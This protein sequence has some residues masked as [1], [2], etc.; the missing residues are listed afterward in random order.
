MEIAAIIEENERRKIALTSPYDPVKGIGCCGRRV[1]CRDEWLPQAVVDEC[2][3]YSALPE[4][5][6]RRVRVRHDFEYWCA[7]CATVR[8]KLTGQPV[9]LTLNAPQRRVLA[10]MESQRTA[11]QPVRVILLKARQW[12]GSTLVQMYMAWM[13]LVRHTGW[14]SLICGHLRQSARSIKGMYRLLLRHYPRELLDDDAPKIE[15]KNF[16]G[17]SD[18]Q[19]ITGRDSL[20]IMGTAVSEDAVR[21]YNLAM[22]HLT[23]VAFWPET[24]MH[25]PQD[26]MRSVNGTVTRTA[27]TVVALESTANGVGQFFHTEWLRANTGESDKQPVFVPW[28]EIE[29]YRSPVRDVLHLWESMDDYERG[30]WRDGRTL[31]MIQW[32]HDKRK[33]AAS[34]A[35]MMAEFP[36][37]D[38]E[39]FVCTDH[40]VFDLEHLDRMRQHCQ[41]PQFTGDV[42]ADYKT[43]NHVHFVQAASGLMKVW[44]LPEPG[45]KYVVAV[46]IGGRSDE[47]DYSVI[48]VLDVRDPANS[49]PEVVAQWRGHLD[50]DLLAWKAAQ[51]ATLYNRAPLVVESNTLETGRGTEGA[52]GKFLLHE[53]ART[54]P[55][56]YRRNATHFGFHTNVS[57][58]KAMLSNLIAA[59]RDGTY[60]ERDHEALDEMAT[61]EHTSNGAYEA[62]KGHHD[63]ILI[64][65]AIGLWMARESRSSHPAISPTDMK[66]LAPDPL[67]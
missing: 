36:T 22:A 9:R 17:S 3:D 57:T 39:A 7:T 21:G 64:T 19:V 6:R 54:Y 20:V 48:A 67:L 53:I 44:R 35:A 15:F 16:E 23:E 31:E 11:G 5:E 12:G 2:P 30:L 42:E 66:S 58:K 8:D 62:K 40:G 65:R 33:E 56:L 47:S 25:S 1:Q 50:H 63:D 52:D 28:Y 14:N 27:D 34:H 51:V 61:Y 55:A 29:L 32:Y 41:P 46:D 13:Q 49:K 60:I 38:T 26:V 10:I 45:V 18:V 24:A 4:V 43:V 37:T 59:V